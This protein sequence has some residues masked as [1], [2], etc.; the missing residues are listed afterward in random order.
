VDDLAPAQLLGRVLDILHSGEVV[1]VLL[2]GG[3]PG[4]VIERHDLEPEVL[5]VADLLDLAQEGGQ[6]GRRDAVDVREEVGRRE[7]VHVGR[8]PAR[9]R[10]HVHV[11]VHLAD[12]L[13]HGV[14]RPV[15]RR[16]AEDDGPVRLQVFGWHGGHLD[17]H[18]LPLA[19]HDRVEHVVVVH[20]VEVGDARDELAVER[21]DHVAF[22][23]P[24][25]VARVYFAHHE[26]LVALRVFV[27][28]FLDPFWWVVSI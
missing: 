27:F 8:R 7:S 13:P 22:L 25:F 21:Q 11:R 1:L 3:D 18:L 14:V 17:A 12:L 16:A 28:D 20:D 5:V 2:H 4:H 6:V 10:R 9:A 15:Q 23:Q 26:E 24:V 19:H